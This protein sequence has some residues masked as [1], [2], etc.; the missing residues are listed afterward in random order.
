MQLNGVKDLN[1][2]NLY[3]PILQMAV[4]SDIAHSCFSMYSSFINPKEHSWGLVGPGRGI[5]SNREAKQKD[6]SPNSVYSARILFPKI[7]RLY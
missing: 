1:V 4:S 5:V 6:D 7:H 3:T 2:L